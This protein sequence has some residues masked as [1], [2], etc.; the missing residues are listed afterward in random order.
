MILSSNDHG[1]TWQNDSTFPG[2]WHPGK[3]VFLSPDSG[4]VIASWG[5][6]PIFIVSILWTAD[7]GLTWTET[8]HDTIPWQ[9][10]PLLFV[11]PMEGYMRYPNG[12]LLHT[13]DGC[14]SWDSI[15]FGFD[16]LIYDVLMLSDTVGFA[17]GQHLAIYSTNDGWKTSVRD[18][19]P[20]MSG[21]AGDLTLFHIAKFGNTIYAVGQENIYKL[22]LNSNPLAAVRV[23]AN[24]SQPNLSVTVNPNPASTF[25]TVDVLG[26][27]ISEGPQTL[28]V[29]DILAREVLRGVIPADGP[30]K[31]DV[32]SL[33]SGLYFVTDGD[34][35]A[36]F[37]K[38]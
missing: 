19:V 7:A 5:N 23:L 3:I 38:E 18:T 37:A 1:A 2:D 20:L 17:V 16:S 30:L 14:K 27:P 12:M 8:F 33:P 36:K 21:D 26:A 35:R 24:S 34:W 6:F 32:S 22:D 10:N 28:K 31:L 11:S 25:V 13:T 9:A 15:H 4:Y 29:I